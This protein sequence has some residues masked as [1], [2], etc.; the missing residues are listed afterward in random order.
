MNR[1]SL[2]DRSWFDLDK[3]K[4][5]E[6]DTYWNGQNHISRATGSQWEHESLYRTAKDSWILHSWSQWQGSVP[7]WNKVSTPE[8]AAWLAA[9]SHD[10]PTEDPETAEAYSELEV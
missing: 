8:A 2:D 5:Y 6:E 10:P 9:N 3:A 4:K 7:T 1:Q